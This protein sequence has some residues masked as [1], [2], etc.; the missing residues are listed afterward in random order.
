MVNLYNDNL[1]KATWRVSAAIR[2]TTE[3]LA[4]L[5]YG[6]FPAR[7]LPNKAYSLR[8]DSASS[9]THRNC[10][11][12]PQ[13]SLFPA[14]SCCHSMPHKNID[15]HLISSATALFFQRL[16]CNLIFQGRSIFGGPL[17]QK[18]RNK[19]SRAP[20]VHNPLAT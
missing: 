4:N 8:I 9:Q 19:T 15:Y 20:L 16:L 17:R 10:S 12:I 5:W 1:C 18:T 3:H 14:F 13:G 11:T 2:P 7:L 6:G